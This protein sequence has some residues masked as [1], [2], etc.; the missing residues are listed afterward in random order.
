MSLTLND[1]TDL[2]VLHAIYDNLDGDAQITA[3][4]L[5]PVLDVKVREAAGRLSWM[6]RIGLLERV[7]AKGR[8]HYVLTPDGIDM[9]DASVPKATEALQ[10]L[11][12]KI[13]GKGRE[14]ALMDALM[15]SDASVVT[16]RVMR[17]TFRYHDGRRER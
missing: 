5:A 6:H 7:P 17:R 8:P 1:M 4:A 15:A 14:V 13:A 3:E 11:T 2:S 9:H 16:A 10:K 12:A